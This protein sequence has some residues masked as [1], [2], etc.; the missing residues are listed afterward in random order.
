MTG[1]GEELHT[2]RTPVPEQILCT[3]LPIHPMKGARPYAVISAHHG[4]ATYL[5]HR[6]NV[7]RPLA[8]L[9]QPISTNRASDTRVSATRRTLFRGQ[10]KCTCKR[11][12]ELV[13]RH[14]LYG[15]GW[16]YHAPRRG[17]NFARL[18]KQWWC[19]MR[20]KPILVL[21]VVSPQQAQYSVLCTS[22]SYNML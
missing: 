8:A 13:Q 12:T 15:V 2:I 10:F 20:M 6:M 5:G 16:T 18:Q 19:E 14:Q 22:I 9:S 17:S 11:D 3:R 4:L 21:R 1:L 7:P